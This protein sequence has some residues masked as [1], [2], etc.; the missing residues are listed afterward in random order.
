MKVGKCYWEHVGDPLGLW[1]EQIE[2]N[3]NSTPLVPTLPRR[4]KL[5]LLG[6]WCNSSLVEQNLYIVSYIIYIFYIILYYSWINFEKIII[7]LF[8][9]HVVWKEN[10]NDLPRL[11]HF[12]CNTIKS[13][14]C[15]TIH[16]GLFN[17]TKRTSPFLNVA[18]RNVTPWF[19]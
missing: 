3:K 9:L 7:I 15:T 18:I 19:S 16:W 10:G 2:I 17:N 14:L 11:L 4:E 6:A 8:F 1:G 12:R 13:P 5:G